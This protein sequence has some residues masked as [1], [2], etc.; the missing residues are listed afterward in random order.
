MP[1]LLL[2]G[3]AD[4]LFTT[5]EAIRNYGI[6]AR[7]SVPLKMMWFCGGH[8]DV[9]DRHR[10]RRATSRRAVIAWLQRYVAGK[11]K[12]ATGP[13]FEWLAD[14]AVW[15]H[16]PALAA[17]ARQGDRR[18]PAPA[19]SPSTRP[20]RPRARRSP[21]GPAANAVNV[22]IPAATAQVV[23]EPKLKLTYS[24]TGTAAYVFAQIVDEKRNLVLGNQVTPLPVTLDGASHTVTRPLEG[25]AASMG[26]AAATT[27][28]SSAAARSTGRCAAPGR[29]RSPA[30]ARAP[31]RRQGGG[32]SRANRAVTVRLATPRV[33]QVRVAGKRVK[34]RGTAGHLRAA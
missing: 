6:L 3:T 8:G 14:D 23:G 5:A 2:Q 32:G 15:R 24:G 26:P 33:G 30:P 9:R 27:C 16:S 11:K 10:A 22:A 19:R 28:R 17:A 31:D 12:V 34:V 13:G 18:A 21:P 1:T 25:V 29:S 4:T 7:N 20:T